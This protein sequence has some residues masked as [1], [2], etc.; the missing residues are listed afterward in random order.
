[1]SVGEERGRESHSKS[2]LDN[3]GIEF[4]NGIYMPKVYYAWFH[5]FGKRVIWF[6]ENVKKTM[7][8]KEKKRKIKN[9]FKVNK[10]F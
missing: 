6:L 5:L 9:R 3:Q 4:K 8:N 10:L 7:E 1:M 2:T